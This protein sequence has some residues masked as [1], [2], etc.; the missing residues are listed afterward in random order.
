MDISTKSK[1]SRM[2]PN[3]FSVCH[4][5]PTIAELEQV[6][7]EPPEWIYKV[8][9]LVPRS[10]TVVKNQLEDCH[11][12]T[13]NFSLKDRIDARS[14]PK[15]LICHD[16]KGGYQADRYLHNSDEDIVGH[17]YTFYN[18]SQIDIF[19]Y[20]SHHFITIP[21]LCWINTG[22][23]NGVKVLGTLITEFSSGHD[24]CDNKIFKDL[25][26][27]KS[28]AES[29]AQVT[30][31]F[32]FDGWLLNI[33]NKVSNVE[34]LKKF[35]PYLTKLIHDDNPGNLIIWYDSV[36]E[37]GE[38]VWQNE[39]NE[40]NQYFFDCCDGIFLNYTWSEKTLEKTALAAKYRSHDVF[41]GV[42]VFGRNMFG[43]GKFH[44]DKAVEVAVR[45][46]LSV[47]IFAPGWTHETLNKSEKFFESFYNR[48]LAFWRSLWPYMYTHPITT[49][50]TTHFYV[51]LDEDCYNLFSQGI[52]LSK[53]LYPS[54]LPLIPEHTTLMLP[55]KC[56]CI[57]GSLIGNKNTCLLTRTNLRKDVSYIHNLFVTDIEIYD[58]TVV[59]FL[60]KSVD[61]VLSVI[62][63]SL[64]VSSYNGSLRKIVLLGQEKEVP[65]ENKTV[66]EVNQSISPDII[67]N[68]RDRY[69]EKIVD[70]RWNLS[71]YI[72][73]TPLSN[74]L[75]VGVTLKSGNSILL[76]AFGIENADGN[77]LK[78]L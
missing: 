78:N 30:K 9:P 71:V 69:Y 36:T 29:L 34:V 6:I 64:L 21:P 38:L 70:E 35:V 13:E 67:R 26:T 49:Y 41:V 56:S 76:G 23:K 63:V 11:S 22:H 25:E 27:M 42:D 51:G 39:L 46:N 28:F 16:Y 20:F 52:Q 55:Y 66:T 3:I 45:L 8:Q 62:D 72:F 44:T 10:G 47:A 50:F 43:G 58:N 1:S 57:Q 14:V 75:E 61:D 33:E 19:V 7:Q 4:P 37:K 48:D 60:T 31:I 2:M 77:F 74:I 40:N 24:I 65:L 18:W 32:G 53:C 5:I 15:F 54:N 17:G 12:E 59:F 68:I 73:S